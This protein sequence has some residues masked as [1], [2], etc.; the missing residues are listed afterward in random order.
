MLPKFWTFWPKNIFPKRVSEKNKMMNISRNNEP[1]LANEVLNGPLIIC[2]CQ[3][4]VASRAG[5]RGQIMATPLNQVGVASSKWA[6]FFIRGCGYRHQVGVV[7]SKWACICGRGLFKT[8]PKT[9]L[10]KTVSKTVGFLGR[11]SLR[12]LLISS[13]TFWRVF[14]PNVESSIRSLVDYC[15]ISQRV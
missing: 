12:Y 11:S 1:I 5:G 15:D 3:V 9:S 10:T 4:G 8:T 2:P 14:R 13:H 7:Y 6:W